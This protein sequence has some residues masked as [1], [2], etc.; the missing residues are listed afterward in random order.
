MIIE[1]H[2]VCTYIYMYDDDDDDD[3]DDTAMGCNGGII[4]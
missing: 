2:D 1:D 4:R 3:D